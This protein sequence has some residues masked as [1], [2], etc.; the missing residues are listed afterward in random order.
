[1]NSRIRFSVTIL[2][3]LGSHIGN[4]EVKWTGGL[5]R[6]PLSAILESLTTSYLCTLADRPTCRPV[7]TLL[8]R[9]IA[10]RLENYTVQGEV[11]DWYCTNSTNA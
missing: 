1:M 7:D 5:F 4:P 8:P 10:V 2:K 11:M 3:P 6:V 9:S